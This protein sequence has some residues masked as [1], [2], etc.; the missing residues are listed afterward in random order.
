MEPRGST[1]ARRR[2]NEIQSQ[3]LSA[4]HD[5]GLTQL[6]LSALVGVASR[7]LRDW[8]KGRDTPSLRHLINWA[9]A[10]E[11]RLAIVD[12]LTNTPH[13]PVASQDDDP[14]EIHELRRLTMPLESIRRQRE[15]SQGDLA[16]LLG[17]SRSSVQRWEDAEKFPRPATLIAWAGRLKCAVRL[18]HV[19]SAD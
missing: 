1:G 17:V 16:L 13:S 3:L 18:D 12:P 9:N 5:A 7:S 4:R 19:G 8:E 11:F 15:L 2:L 6:T 14:F 10:L